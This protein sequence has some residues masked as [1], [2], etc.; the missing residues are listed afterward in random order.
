MNKFYRKP[1]PETMRKNRKK[2]A[3]AYGDEIKWF[4]D[5]LK[6]LTE[7]KNKF[8]NEADVIMFIIT[9]LS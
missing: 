4:K 1:K 2:Y 9:R 8:F 7:T 6:T 5:N 3:E